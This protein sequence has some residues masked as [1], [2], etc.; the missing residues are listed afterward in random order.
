MILHAPRFHGAPGYL[1]SGVNCVYVYDFAMIQVRELTK[2][3]GERPAV[4]DLSFDIDRG[5]VIGFLGLNGAGKTT[6]LKILG[7]VL[8]PT[9]GTVVV[10][11]LDVTQRP[12]QVRRRIGFLPDVPPLYNEMT[13]G[14][15]LAFAA[16]L[17][18]VGPRDVTARVGEAEEKTA[19]RDMHGE[20]ISSLSHGYRQRVGLAQA[21]VHKPA[22]LILDEPTAGL[23]PMQIV[24]MRKLIRQLR[25][26]HTLLISS[27]F[28]AEISQTCDRL[29]VIQKGEIVAQGSEDDLATSMGTAGDIEI[30]VRGTAERAVPVIRAVQ[31]VVGVTVVGQQAGEVSLRVQTREDIRPALVRAV[32]GNGLDLLRLD[33]A[34]SRLE[35]IFIQLARSGQGGAPGADAREGRLS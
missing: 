27:H 15:Y 31:G 34:S 21:M 24:E 11:G 2:Y 18:G 33:R 29:L 22:L 4:Q 19:L 35:S 6:T 32:V 17:R 20:V 12:H 1:V 10:D 13:V 8:L 5:E 14:S 26:E 28:L 30:E 16:R 25:G 7:C 3:Y 23:D 9:S